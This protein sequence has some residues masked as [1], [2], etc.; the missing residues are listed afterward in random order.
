MTEVQYV[1]VEY[2][3]KPLPIE[4]DRRGPTLILTNSVVESVGRLLPK[5]VRRKYHENVL[6]IAGIL[7]PM[8]R[9]GLT[10]IAPKSE[11]G[12]GHYRTDRTSHSEVLDVLGELGMVVVAQVHCHPGEGVYH[13]D[14]DDDLA[15]VRAEGHWSIV[16]PHYGRK[17]MLPLA[18]CGFHRL[19]EGDFAY[20]SDEAVE[21]RVK[22]IP[23]SIR[24]TENI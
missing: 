24:L 2:R 16:V 8:R 3:R 15:F 12:P 22:V 23:A 5:R 11:T 13:S 18:Q 4:R 19:H 6:Y 20:L 21:A 17:G 1:R 9:T 10:V 14:A 7:E